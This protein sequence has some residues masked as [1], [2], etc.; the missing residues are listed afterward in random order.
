MVS[1]VRNKFKNY[2]LNDD[3]NAMYEKIKPEL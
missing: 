1:H 2:A 3:L